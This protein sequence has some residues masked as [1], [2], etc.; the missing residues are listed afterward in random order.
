MR[1]DL[2]FACCV[3]LLAAMSTLAR[4][5]TAEIAVSVVDEQ[6]RPVEDAVVVA[7]PADG[8]VRL[9]PRTRPEMVDQVD[10]EFRPRVKTVLVGTAV[11]FPNHDNVR[12]HV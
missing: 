9:P 8:N 5:Q 2:R 12:H 11:T 10:K 1:L 3:A 6:G 7:V 4:A